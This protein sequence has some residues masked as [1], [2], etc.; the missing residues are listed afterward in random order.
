MMLLSAWFVFRFG[1]TDAPREQVAAQENAADALDAVRQGT[2]ESHFTA[3]DSAD[4]YPMFHVR[5]VIDELT[6]RGTRLRKDGK[7]KSDAEL[8]EGLERRTVDIEL[9]R[10]TAKEIS[11]RE[12]YRRATESVYIVCSMYEIKDTDNWETSLATAFAVTSEG[13]LST[14]CHVFD[15]EDDADVVVVMDVHRKV[16]AVQELLAVN[17]QADT[18]L[19]RIDADETR[20]LPLADDAPPGTRVRVLGHPGDSFYFLSSGALANYE[21]DNDGATWLNITAD[22]G[23]GSSGGPVMD[24][25][26][27]VI[28][29]V[30]RTY[31][32]YAGGAATRGRPR[33]VQDEKAAMETRETEGKV[34]ATDDIADPQMVFKSCVPVRTLRSLVKS[35]KAAAIQ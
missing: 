5:E 21:R 2:R 26:G 20:P 27:N 13:V 18:C 28:G 34:K 1:T 32:L 6:T 4:A 22:F 30:S 8:R 17:R 7:S 24:E 11:D 16:Y 31:T 9:P 14:S 10:P 19:F 25:C 12:L 15:N 29:Q 33:R 3:P 23:Q 35:T